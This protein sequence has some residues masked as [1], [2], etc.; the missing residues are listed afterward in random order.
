MVGNVCCR[1]KAH[2]CADGNEPAERE[3]L[4]MMENCRNDALEEVRGTGLGLGRSPVYGMQQV[5]QRSG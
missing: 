5:G 3:K 4:V 1:Y 2:L